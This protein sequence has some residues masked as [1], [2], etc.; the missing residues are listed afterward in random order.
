MKAKG[1]GLQEKCKFRSGPP[2]RRG[3]WCSALTLEVCP[4]PHTPRAAQIEKNM[5]GGPTGRPRPQKR[6]VGSRGIRGRRVDEG[7]AERWSDATRCEGQAHRAGRD[8]TCCR[9]RVSR[10]GFS[11][12][13]SGEAAPLSSGFS[14]LP[15]HRSSRHLERSGPFVRTRRASASSRPWGRRG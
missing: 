5:E 2:E 13:L 3:A 9:G 6:G 1:W 15:R 14:P 8:R 10:T 4:P 12:Q 11:F 7:H